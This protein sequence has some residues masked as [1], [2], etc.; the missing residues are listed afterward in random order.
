MVVQTLVYDGRLE[1]VTNPAVAVAAGYKS[2]TQLFKVSKPFPVPNYYTDIPCG[3][4]PVID[5]C[6]EDG[7]I[8]PSTCEY[9]TQWLGANV[10]DIST[11]GW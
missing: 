1:E 9:M 11:G 6:C 8:S 5:R 10:D 2:G 7:V 4:C 3:V